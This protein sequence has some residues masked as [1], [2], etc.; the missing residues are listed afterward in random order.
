MN[1]VVLVF[2]GLGNA[3]SSVVGLYESLLH[4][5]GSRFDIVAI[6][7]AVQHPKSFVSQFQLP[8]SA[9]YANL[10]AFLQANSH[11][12]V[13]AAF[14]LTPVGTHLSIIEQVSNALDTQGL[15]FVVEKPSFSL[16]EIDRGFNQVIPELKRRGAQ[17]YFIDTALVAPSLEALFVGSPIALPDG[18]P[19]KIIAIAADNPI[20]SHEAIQGFRFENRIELLNA[21]KLLNL[22]TSGGGGYGFDMGIHAIAGLVRYLHKS[23]IGDSL[24][25]LKQTCAERISESQLEYTQGAETHLYVE[26]ELTSPEGNIEVLIEA[27]KAGDIWDRRLELHY[28][29]RIIAIGFGTLKHPPYLWEKSPDGIK[30][31]T[32][33]VSGSGYAMHFNDILCALGFDAKPRLSQQESEALMSQSMNLLSSVF[34]AIGDT[35][36][37]REQNIAVVDAHTP[38]YLSEAELEIRKELSQYLDLLIL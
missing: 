6:D 20:D 8:Y 22:T 25:E 9:C 27:G 14:V 5:L 37:V 35:Y 33:D 1:K 7:P 12:D 30:S 32:F 24:V 23:S 19:N 4:T 26:G 3:K 13:A 38:K 18:V 29:K 16:A 21:R 15:L 10:N 2:G 36:Q 11:T 34:D 31:T 17:F 28:P